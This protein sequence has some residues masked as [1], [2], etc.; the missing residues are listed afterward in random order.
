MQRY[1]RYLKS[2]LQPTLEAEQYASQ[3]QRTAWRT[4]R[5]S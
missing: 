5:T 3:P 4:Y 1:L 2:D